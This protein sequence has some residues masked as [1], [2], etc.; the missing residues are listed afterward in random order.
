MSQ[1]FIQ[2][3]GIIPDTHFPLISKKLGISRYNYTIIECGSKDTI[4]SYIKLLNKFKIKYVVVY[5]LDHHTGK[6]TGAIASAD[7]SSRLIEDEIDPSLGSSII[8]ENDIEEEVGFSS[9]H[10]NKPYNASRHV[11]SDDF[12]ISSSLKKKVELIYS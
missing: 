1:L 7:N 4:P 5:D 12:A 10:K 6:D 2:C 8:L 9:S 11:E 3:L